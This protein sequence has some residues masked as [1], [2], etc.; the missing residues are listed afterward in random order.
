MKFPYV[1]YY[2]SDFQKEG[3]Q[4]TV[5]QIPSVVEESSLLPTLVDGDIPSSIG[6]DVAIVDANETD[7]STDSLL[8]SLASKERGQS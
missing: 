5:Y 3:C 1:N 6:V 2:Y 8:D 7:T 4:L